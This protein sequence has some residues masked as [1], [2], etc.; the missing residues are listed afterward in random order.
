M[1]LSQSVTYAVRAALRL[2]ECSDSG[3]ISCGR[4]AREGN[5]PERFLLQIL[6]DLTKKGILRSTRGGGGG[7]TLARDADSVTLLELIEVIDG[8]IAPSMPNNVALPDPA[9][10]VLRETLERITR[11]ARRQLATI[12]LRSLC[13][14]SVLGEGDGEHHHTAGQTREVVHQ[15]H[16]PDATPPRPIAPMPGLP[17]A[18][19]S[20]AAADYSSVHSGG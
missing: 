4:L 11:N 15:L 7:F 19:P 3:P 14:R 20:V 8:P 9:S 10:A 18:T 12:T 13:D 17:L 16:T 5:M 1:K 2:A 6:R